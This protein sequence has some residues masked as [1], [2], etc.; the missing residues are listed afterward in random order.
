MTQSGPTSSSTAPSASSF[1]IALALIAGLAAVLLANAEADVQ[2]QMALAGILAATLLVLRF[3]PETPFIRILILAIGGFTVIRYFVWRLSTTMEYHDPVSY[4]CAVILLF[5][6]CYGI[7]FIMMTFTVNANPKKRES[8]PLTGKDPAQLPSVDVLVPSYNEAP[9]LIAITLVAARQMRYDGIVNVYL[10]DD[11]GTDAKCNQKDLLLAEEA[12]NRR[13]ELTALCQRLG[14]TY[15]TRERNEHAKAGNLNI[16]LTNTNGDLVVI[17]DADHVP[18]ADFLENTVGFFLEDPKLFLVQTPHFFLNPDPFERNLMTFDTMPSENEMFY[19]NIQ[20]GLD[21]WNSSFFCGSAA[22]LRREW[23]NI[24]G[25]FSGQS[26]TEDAETAIELHSRGYHSAYLARPMIAGLAAETVDAFVVQRMRWAQ[27]MIQI[28]RLKSP[29]FRKSK[30]SA[31]QRLCYLSSCQFWFFPF[32]RLTYM[33]AP[34]A[35][36]LFDLQIYRAYYETFIAFVVPYMLTVIVISHYLFKRTRWILISEIYE[37]VQSVFCLPVV[38]QALFRPKSGRFKVTPKAQ[39]LNR[40]FIS[41]MAIP[42]Y[43]LLAINLACA[44][45]GVYKL[46]TFPDTEFAPTLITL[47][48]VGFNLA[49][50]GCALGVMT[51]TRQLRSSPRFPVSAPIRIRHGDEIIEGT[52]ADM[53]ASGCG[54]HIARDALKNPAF[55]Q[56]AEIE[57][58]GANA[59]LKVEM[60]RKV[61][62]PDLGPTRALLGTRFYQ[63]DWT[64]LETAVRLFYG[65]S[66]KWVDFQ[67]R[68]QEHAPGIIR[69]LLYVGRLS[70]LGYARNLR[71]GFRQ[72][73]S[74]RSNPMD[75]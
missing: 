15:L 8:I 68:R 52:L 19:S 64:T 46:L 60:V 38:I 14:A 50:L 45:R 42:F 10:L 48:W 25:G 58:I 70:L 21:R 62:S 49:L 3:L 39:T 17:F 71:V 34:A 59:T 74:M 54:I 4:T 37:L 5:A 11:G 63:G 41:K 44:T 40:A 36:L 53:S 12:K 28:F 18:T 9:D 13:A 65:D 73:F 47:F 69:T 26:I 56:P 32:A 43:V 57:I 61:M 23:L 35:F 67:Q 75:R 31:A 33:L 6:E 51:E 55:P 27:G 16:G 20:Q 29:I 22:V 1:S 7:A 72:L 30:L 2:N 66:Q 24:T